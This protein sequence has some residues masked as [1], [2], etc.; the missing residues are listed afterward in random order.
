HGAS[1]VYLLGW[2][3]GTLGGVTGETSVELAFGREGAGLY[4]KRSIGL[5]GGGG[6]LWSDEQQQTPVAVGG[7]S[8]KLRFA[9]YRIGTMYTPGIERLPSINFDVRMEIGGD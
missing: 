9:Q 2:S 3:H 1:G 4:P 5:Y 8:F 6:W 7:V